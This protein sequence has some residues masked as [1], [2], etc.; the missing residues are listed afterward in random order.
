MATISPTITA[1]GEHTR[2]ATWTFTEAD[3]CV[4]VGP[5]YADY[6]DRNVQ[7]GGTFGGATVVLQGSNDDSTYAAITDPQG[8]PIS[9]TTAALEACTEVPLFVK[10]TT[11]GGTAQTSTVILVMRRGRGGMEV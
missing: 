4:P 7:I 11:S 3:T 5:A 10:P 6:S 2:V 9:K 1:A 8:N